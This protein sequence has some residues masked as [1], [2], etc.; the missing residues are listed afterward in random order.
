MKEIPLERKPT[1][2]ISPRWRRISPYLDNG[3]DLNSSYY[4]A[5]GIGAEQLDDTL[6]VTD[7]GATSNIHIYYSLFLTQP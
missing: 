2:Q 5:F 4:Q 3:I 7:K 1:P 6:E